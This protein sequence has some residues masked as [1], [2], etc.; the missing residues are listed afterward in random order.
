MG[1]EHTTF[2]SSDQNLGERLKEMHLPCPVVGKP[3]RGR[4]SYGVKVGSSLS[5]LESHI[6]ELFEASPTV[7]IE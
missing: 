1:L 3:I 6:S 2:N 4:G 5:T 7:I